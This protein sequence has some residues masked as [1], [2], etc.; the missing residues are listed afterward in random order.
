LRELRL[1]KEA[2]EPKRPKPEP[3]FY[4]LET[5]LIFGKHVGKTIE[6]IIEDDVGYI[7]WCLENIETFNLDPKAEDM[8]LLELD[9]RR[10]PQAW[11]V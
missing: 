3:I 7:T 8:Y 9:P 11:E 2:S 6:Q 5:E 1:A 10:G 4:S